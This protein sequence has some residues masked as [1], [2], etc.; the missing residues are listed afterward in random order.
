MLGVWGGAERPYPQPSAS[1]V[2]LETAGLTS[3][4][5]HPLPRRLPKVAPTPL[6]FSHP[7]TCEAVCSASVS[8]WADHWVKRP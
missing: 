4:R 8:S 2:N 6:F 3:A 5:L 1:D 7:R